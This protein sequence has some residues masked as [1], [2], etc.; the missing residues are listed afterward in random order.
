[1]AGLYDLGENPFYEGNLERTFLSAVLSGGKIPAEITVEHFRV[2]DNRLVFLALKRLEKLE[3][4]SSLHGAVVLYLSGSG[5]MT[6][7]QAEPAV[8]R[9]EAL[10]GDPRFINAYARELI[11]QNLRRTAIHG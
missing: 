6:K 2:S 7:A 10:S 9:I 1:M 11:L 8:K 5:C 3:I 4:G